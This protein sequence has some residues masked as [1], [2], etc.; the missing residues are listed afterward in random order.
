MTYRVP[1]PADRLLIADFLKALEQGDSLG[2]IEAPAFSHKQQTL[3]KVLA[4]MASRDEGPL[5]FACLVRAVRHG[6]KSTDLTTRVQVM[7]EAAN[8]ARA[9]ADAQTA[10]PA[11][12][13]EVVS[14]DA[15]DIG[16]QDHAE[17]LA[18]AA[19][20]AGACLPNLRRGVL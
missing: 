18:Q 10:P 19:A 16:Q 20:F 7:A 9:F 14:D 3:G 12:E 8:I 6:L 15:D 11:A 4:D 1:T 5:M 2:L 17:I 13:V